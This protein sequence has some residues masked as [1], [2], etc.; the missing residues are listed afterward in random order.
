MT[1][2]TILLLPG[3]TDIKITT[4]NEQETVIHYTAPPWGKNKVCIYVLPCKWEIK[5]I[6]KHMVTLINHDVI[7]NK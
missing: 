5:T 1:T 7:I 2:K 4:S 6:T 3:A